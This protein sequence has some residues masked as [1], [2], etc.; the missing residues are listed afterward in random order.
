[1]TV[2]FATTSG[3]STRGANPVL[4][5]E[6]HKAALSG[7]VRTYRIRERLRPEKRRGGVFVT[8]RQGSGACLYVSKNAAHIFEGVGFVDIELDNLE[9]RL[10]ILPDTTGEGWAIVA[11]KT[12]GVQFG[13]SKLAEKLRERGWYP[14]RYAARI[15]GQAV[16]V[17][18]GEGG[19]PA[20]RRAQ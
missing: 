17:E 10:V 3:T 14:G 19:K 4:R 6:E 15:E 16:I 1:M 11:S 9:R 20:T 8:F 7:P 5:G 12:A 18:L 2:I 13:S